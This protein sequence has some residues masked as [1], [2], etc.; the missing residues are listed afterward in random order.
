MIL[1]FYP[2]VLRAERIF[3]CTVQGKRTSKGPVKSLESSLRCHRKLRLLVPG[4]GSEGSATRISHPTKQPR[5]NEL[6]RGGK[7][8]NRHGKRTRESPREIPDICE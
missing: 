8:L 5:Q 2:I 7:S 1:R 3:R 6:H 4:T